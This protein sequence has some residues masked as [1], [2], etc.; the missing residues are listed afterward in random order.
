MLRN[1]LALGSEI[2]S[3]LYISFCTSLIQ[4]SNITTKEFKLAVLGLNPGY[5]TLI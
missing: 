2:L 5:Y 4:A 3:I 1:F